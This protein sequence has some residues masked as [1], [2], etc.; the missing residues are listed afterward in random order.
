MCSTRMPLW[1]IGHSRWLAW[2]LVSHWTR[3][4][5]TLVKSVEFYYTLPSTPVWSYHSST[6]VWS[7]SIK[8]VELF[9]STIGVH[10]NYTLLCVYKLSHCL[11]TC[12]S[13]SPFESLPACRSHCL[14]HCLWSVPLVA[15]LCVFLFIC[16][17]VVLLPV[18]LSACSYACLFVPLHVY[19]HLS[20]CPSLLLPACLSV[21]LSSCMFFRL[22]VCC[23]SL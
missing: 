22:H 13:Y 1:Y 12:S 16:L 8:S 4:N 21:S 3:W 11:P 6:E 20:V 17:P 7:L 5:C 10:H 18:C 14:S 23:L 9:Y 15:C 19:L 2:P